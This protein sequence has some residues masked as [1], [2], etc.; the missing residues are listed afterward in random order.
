MTVVESD[1][2]LG[3]VTL[4]GDMFWDDENKWSS[5]SQTV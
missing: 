3:S 4:P 2:T 1:I 5:I